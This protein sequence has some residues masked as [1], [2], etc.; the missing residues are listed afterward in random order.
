MCVGRGRRG[1]GRASQYPG[2][3]IA[4][5]AVA[6]RQVAE[7]EHTAAKTLFTCGE[8]VACTY[9]NKPAHDVQPIQPNA[10]IRPHPKHAACRG[11]RGG[12]IDDHIAALAREGH[13]CGEYQLGGEH[14][15]RSESRKQDVRPPCLDGRWQRLRAIDGAD[16]MGAERRGR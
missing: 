7:A 8:V 9:I 4:Q 13:V 5:R 1:E 6:H 12:R 15:R 16:A 14:V 10:R 2:R 3:V 11:G